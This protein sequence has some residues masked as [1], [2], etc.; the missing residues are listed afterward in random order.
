M[1]KRSGN[2]LLAGILVALMGIAAFAAAIYPATR[3]AG[4]DAEGC[5]YVH[6]S[7]I[8]YDAVSRSFQASALPWAIR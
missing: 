6:G 8:P 4:E 3:D 1:A 7:C 5:Y 2:K